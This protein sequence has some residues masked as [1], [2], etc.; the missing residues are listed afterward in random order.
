MSEMELN[1]AVRFSLKCANTSKIVSDLTRAFGK[2]PDEIEEYNG[3]VEYFRYDHKKNDG[4][5]VH[6]IGDEVFADYILAEGQEH[7]DIN[8]DITDEDLNN[9]V[10]IAN[11]KG[12]EYTNYKIKILYFYNGGCAGL[13]EVK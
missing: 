1:V 4:F 2:E 12:L 3:V 8:I 11:K 7:Y 10:S 5:A 6:V 13:S 9:I